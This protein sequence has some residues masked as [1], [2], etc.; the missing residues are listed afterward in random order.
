MSSATFVER[1][2]TCPSCNSTG[3]F[4][5]LSSTRDKRGQVLTVRAR[6][7]SCGMIVLH[8]C[9]TS[10]TT[11][12]PQRPVSLLGLATRATKPP[13]PKVNE[14]N[15]RGPGAPVCPKCERPGP[16]YSGGDVRENGAV[17]VR[18]IVCQCGARLSYDGVMCVQVE[19]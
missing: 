13:P 1:G 2:M 3:R 19:G 5:A 8:D 17:I 12:A 9:A 6:C 18:T 7:L 10:T 15:L 4:L 14:N 16:Y 11:I